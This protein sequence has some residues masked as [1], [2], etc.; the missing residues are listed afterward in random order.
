MPPASRSLRLSV[1]RHQTAG[2]FCEART[3][4]Q[5]ILPSDGQRSLPRPL[6]GA[7]LRPSGGQ[8]FFHLVEGH[9]A[10]ARLDGLG[11]QVFQAAARRD[12][13]DELL[14]LP[15]EPEGCPGAEGEARLG[16]ERL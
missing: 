2:W 4:L 15:E 1:D 11:A 6:V 12:L 9:H 10:D 14:A 13:E 8:M 5:T 7:T 3:P 16:A